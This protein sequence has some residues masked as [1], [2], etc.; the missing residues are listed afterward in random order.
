MSNVNH[1]CAH[2]RNHCLLK[3]QGE[4]APLCPQTAMLTPRGRMLLPHR[5]SPVNANDVNRQSP[6]TINCNSV[7]PMPNY[8]LPDF[9]TTQPY[10]TQELGAHCKYPKVTNEF[11]S[12]RP[13][14]S[15]N[16]P[17]KSGEMG[18]KNLM[19]FLEKHAPGAIKHTNVGN[20]LGRRIAIDASMQIYQFL[21]A[22]RHMTGQLVDR[23]GNPTSHLQ[24]LLT[25]TFRL[26]TNGVKPIYVFDGKPP[27][28]KSGE[29]QKRAERKA[30][31][32]KALAEAIEAGNEEDV[33]KFSRRAVAMKSTHI[34]DCKKLLELM[35]VPFVQ[36]PCEAEAECAAL[37][38]AGI[39]Y[40]TATEDMDA[41]AHEAPVLVR[42][43]SSGQDDLVE[44]DYAKVLEELGLT[45]AQFVDFCI[46]C[47]C[48]YCGTIKG[49]GPGKAYGLIK[50]HKTI[51][52][53][54]EV[55]DTTKYPVSDDFNFEGARELFLH[56]EV[57]T[58]VDIK[59]GKPDLAGMKAFMCD[60]K[61]FSETRIENVCKNLEKL[62]A[63]GQQTRMDSFFA[64]VAKP[65]AKGKEKAPAK[66]PPVKGK[67]K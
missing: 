64:S 33:D 53:I 3:L 10:Q 49:I 1:K 20:L 5:E 36:A 42:H 54:L 39:A 25:R 2:A 52:R 56:H 67:K 26:L 62:K 47:G 50:E 28:M 61:G 9:P 65:A 27:E 7:S 19:K 57:T 37:C 16:C 59:W 30:E 55:I 58:E 8:P 23:E 32:E 24:G 12:I 48:D 18:V 35:G 13:H 60:E 66:K 6:I 43:L 31:A 4:A 21:V 44:I 15:T 41:L 17:A 46:L 34:E 22:V 63:G 45:K 29:L 11:P 38:R 40:A 51:E 14:T